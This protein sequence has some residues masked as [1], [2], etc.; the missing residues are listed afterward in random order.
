MGGT[1]THPERHLHRAVLAKLSSVIAG[2]PFTLLHRAIKERYIFQAVAL[3]VEILTRAV[4]TLILNM[5]QIIRSSLYL[6]YYS[7]S[8]LFT[9]SSKKSDSR[10]KTI[11]STVSICIAIRKRASSDNPAFFVENIFTYLKETYSISYQFTTA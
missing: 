4:V 6:C 11:D 9:S 2:D 5:Q 10:K 3:S 8:V 7:S 1:S